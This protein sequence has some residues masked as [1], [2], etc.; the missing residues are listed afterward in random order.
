MDGLV[1]KSPEKDMEKLPACR[2][3]RRRPSWDLQVYCARNAVVLS[4]CDDRPG[5]AH[6]GPGGCLLFQPA[7]DA[8]KPP[9]QMTDAELEDAL[10]TEVMGWSKHADRTWRDSLGRVRSVVGTFQPY[11]YWSTFGAVV[12]EL[13]SLGFRVSITTSRLGSEVSIR[14]WLRVPGLLSPCV[15]DKRPV[16]WVTH[17]SSVFRAGCIAALLAVRP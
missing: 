11:R 13:R 4:R 3:M 1:D 17:P 5:R 2:Y 10:A 15:L 8:G 14:A 16:A 7:T 9:E 12:D 6:S